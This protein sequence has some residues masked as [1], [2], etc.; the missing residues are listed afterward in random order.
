MVDALRGG[1]ASIID[2]GGESTRPGATPIA[3][4]EEL[5][6]VVPIV[7]AIAARHPDLVVSIDTVRGAT[8]EAAI[9]A[10]ATIIN[11]VMAGRH[12]ASLLAV[13][14]RTGAGLVLTHSRGPLGA[15]ASYEHAE[16]D[17][18]VATGV[19]RELTI[20]RDAALAAGVTADAIAVDPGF[21]FAK[22]PEQNVQLL[23]GLDALS[24]M[25]HPVLVGVSRKRFLGELT[26]TP[27]ED[28]DRATAAACA[29]AAAQGAS[30]FRVHAPAA[31][32][33]AVMIAD[34][35]RRASQ[36]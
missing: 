23:A 12:D 7:A 27:L 4:D 28:R 31:V 18:D 22:T 21:G 34:A 19:V 24:A 26:G 10:G 20:A 36:A 1:G 11:D 3:A 35:M 13:A 2:V 17:G 9:A 16:Y 6:R 8:A 29:L 5:E 25:G 14:A 15:L 33:D 30:L 32:R